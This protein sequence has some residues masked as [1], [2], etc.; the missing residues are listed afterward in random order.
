MIKG[1]FRQLYMPIA[2]KV[3]VV[4]L[5]YS[6]PMLLIMMSLPKF[7]QKLTVKEDQLLFTVLANQIK[8]LIM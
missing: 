8:Q 5:R 6:M 7:N 3:H 1:G 4:S 2:I